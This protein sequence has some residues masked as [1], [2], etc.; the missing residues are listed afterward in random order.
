VTYL[1]LFSLLQKSG[2]PR[3][4]LNGLTALFYG[5]LAFVMWLGPFAAT[6]LVTPFFCLFVG[7]GACIQPFSRAARDDWSHLPA[8]I[9]LVLVVLSLWLLESNM[10]RWPMGWTLSGLGGW[11]LMA[12][13]LR[14]ALGFHLRE[15]EGLFKFGLHLM[16]MITLILTTWSLT[17][18]LDQNVLPAAWQKLAPLAW[19]GLWLGL[20]GLAGL[21]PLHLSFIDL[22]DSAQQEDFVYESLVRGS[23][24]FLVLRLVLTLDPLAMFA[25]L[26][27]LG[28][29]ALVG[30]VWCQLLSMMQT[31][32]QRLIS[33][34]FLAFLSLLVVNGVWVWHGPDISRLEA[35]RYLMAGALLYGTFLLFVG[36]L[37]SSSWSDP[38]EPILVSD[39]LRDLPE[40]SLLKHYLRHVLYLMALAGAVLFVHQ[41]IVAWQKHNLVRGLMLVAALAIGGRAWWQLIRDRLPQAGDSGP[42]N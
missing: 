4:L 36:W 16:V 37:T 28:G 23:V 32:L 31:N 24:F 6:L 3:Y 41:F 14:R 40:F 11:L 35:D 12:Y 25:G 8:Q 5:L 10:F 22:L 7:V 34:Q 13:G 17:L 39:L 9:F 1:V 20:I 38:D 30:F 33:Y 18:A 21:W 15:W 42:A 27:L 2:W 26:K 29:L 19:A